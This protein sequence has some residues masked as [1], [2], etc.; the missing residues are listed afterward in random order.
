MRPRPDILLRPL[1]L[2]ALGSLIL[3]DVYLKYEFHN[4]L[5]G[6]LSDF[7]GLFLFP[8]FISTLIIKRT[9][10]IY[11]LTALMFIWWKSEYSQFFIDSAQ[12]IGIPIDRVPD[13][14]DLSA[15]LVLPISYFRFIKE[16]NTKA[17]V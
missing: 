4:I 8:Y 16:L 1:F 17:N 7:A 11:W 13:P 6:K 5:T 12:S 3:N 14:W 2:I 15:L 10:H 9:K